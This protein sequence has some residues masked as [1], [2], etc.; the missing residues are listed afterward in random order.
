[1]KK[2]IVSVVLSLMLLAVF[3]IPVAAD[4]IPASVTVNSFSSVTI[5]DNGDSGLLFGSQNPGTVKTPEAGSPSITITAASENNQTVTIVV[6]GVNFADGGNSIPIANAFWNAS[7]NSGTATAMSTTPTTV[8]TLDAGQ[9]LNIY[10]WLTIP[11][12]QAAGDYTSTFTYG[13]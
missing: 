12:S 4:D 3:A 13:S 2:I 5:T 6:S 8:G 1:M 11:A 9:S 7:D 10:H